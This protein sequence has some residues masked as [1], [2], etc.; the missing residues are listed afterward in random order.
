MEPDATPQAP[1]VKVGE[2]VLYRSKRD[3]VMPA[4]V[5][6]L[7]DETPY[8]HLHLFPPPGEAADNLDHNWGAPYGDGPGHWRA[9]E[10]TTGAVAP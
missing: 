8:V 5:T 2:I 10:E 7:T 6:A 4:I 1:T 3:V 9:R